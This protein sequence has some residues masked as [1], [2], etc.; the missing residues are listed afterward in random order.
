M[1]LIPLELIF[2]YALHFFNRGPIA[3]V[4]FVGT[5][6]FYF[7]CEWV[8]RNISFFLE[9]LTLEKFIGIQLFII[10]SPVCCIFFLFKHL[11]QPL[12]HSWFSLLGLFLFFFL[13][14]LPLEFLWRI[15]L[16]LTDILYCLSFSLIS[17]SPP[18]NSL[19]LFCYSF[20][21]ELRWMCCVLPFSCCNFQ[22]LHLRLY[23]FLSTTSALSHKVWW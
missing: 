20:S 15:H 23:T 5:W 8:L 10:A 11:Q 19:S 1:S 6:R 21:N 22:Y 18:S 16:L 7:L 4:P 14:W 2:V 13:H 12:F 17:T 9:I 3:P